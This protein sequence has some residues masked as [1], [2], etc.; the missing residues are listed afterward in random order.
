MHYLF[1]I[2]LL[3]VTINVTCRVG[4]DGGFDE[5]KQLVEEVY[6]NGSCGCHAL[7]K[8]FGY[9]QRARLGTVLPM[10]QFVYE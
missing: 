6:S 5:E 3:W 7:S 2:M 10:L 8:T 9:Q 4:R 1:N